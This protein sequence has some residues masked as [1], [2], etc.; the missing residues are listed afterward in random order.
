MGALADWAPRELRQP[1]GLFHRMVDDFLS[2]AVE[3]ETEEAAPAG[4]G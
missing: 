3:D 2:H 4:T 1:A